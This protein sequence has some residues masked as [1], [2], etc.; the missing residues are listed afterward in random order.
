MARMSAEKN[1]EYQAK[2]WQANKELQILR[3]KNRV[4]ILRQLLKEYKEK[5]PCMDCNQYYPSYVMDFDHR[6]D[7]ALNVSNAPARGWSWERTLKEIDKC[8]L[9]CAN[10]H[11]IRT[12]QREEIEDF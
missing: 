5:R 2:W 8:D 3:V 1:R 10:C 4:L 6:E 9:I 7:K 11:R 12:W